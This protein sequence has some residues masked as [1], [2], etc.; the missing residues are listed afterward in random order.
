MGN[1]NVFSLLTIAG[2]RTDGW[3]VS[4]RSPRLLRR[5]E[6]YL[7]YAYAHAEGAG[8]IS[9][10]LTDFSPPVSRY[11]LLDHDQR[12]TLHSGFT[13]S[14]PRRVAA[15][16]TSITAQGLPMAIPP[17]LHIFPHLRL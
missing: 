17:Y 4:I 9:G 5:G 8:G 3:E 15:G 13:F 12:H 2:A 6:V 10:G 7:S 11:S 1:S 14:L 16:E